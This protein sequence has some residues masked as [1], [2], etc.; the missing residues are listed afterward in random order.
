MTTDHNCFICGRSSTNP[1][2]LDTD[3]PER[4]QARANVV[5]VV[6]CLISTGIVRG[7]QACS[8]FV[9]RDDFAWS[10]MPPSIHVKDQWRDR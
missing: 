9:S 7:Y 2:L 6:Q 4:F 3:E 10:P 1:H 8:R 5:G